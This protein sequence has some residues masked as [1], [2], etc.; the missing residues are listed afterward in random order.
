MTSSSNV[1]LDQSLPRTLDA[2]V[3]QFSQ[4][5]WHGAQLEA[6][7]FE[8]AEA[9]RAAEETLAAAGV[10][11][12][13]RSAYKPL[14]HFFL[15]EVDLGQIAS[16]QVCYPVHSAATAQ[17]FW[18][19]AYPLAALLPAGVL[20]GVAGGEALVYQVTLRLKDGST[21]QHQV[22]APNQLQ[23]DPLGH[24]LL[25]PTGWLRAV[26][27]AGATVAALDQACR[28]EVEQL[29]AQ[30]LSTVQQ[31]P[32]PQTEPYFER[33]DIRLDLPGYE[34]AVPGMPGA[35]ETIST[36][37]AL[38]EDLYFSLLEI[39]QHH[40]GRPTGDRR[41]QPGQIVPDVRFGAPRVCITLNSFNTAAQDACAP[42]DT[43]DGVALDALGAAPPPA[44][45][46]HE[47]AQLGGQTF[48][49]STRQGR[50]VV[51]LYRTGSQA[52]VLISGGQHANE[53]SG[54][55]GTLRAAQVLRQQPDAHFALI[56]LENPDGYAM[57]REL[58]AQH[59]EHMHHAARY[60]ALGDD[61]E[62]RETAPLF[63]R[64]AREH[65]LTLSGAQLHL[66]L[67]GYPAHEWT[68]PLSGYIPRGFDL[69]TI[70]KGFFLILRYHT[71]WQAQA[72]ALLEQVCAALREVPGLIDFNAQQMALYAEHAGPMPFPVLDGTAYT[73]SEVNRP[74]APVTLITEFPD[75][76]V[77]GDAFRFAHSVQMATVLAA[78][79]AWQNIAPPLVNPS[80]Q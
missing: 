59:G 2:W 71:G 47:M 24:E 48:N 32:W 39:F 26:P 31:H 61:I 78:T 36:L 54:I 33:L 49:A 34:C 13:L 55:V 46:Q 11:A 14:L 80:K 56:A 23:R 52:P 25:S 45:I 5:A 70:P 68:R 77:Y 7:L 28:T 69:W 73:I 38:H 19:E 18:L 8:G 22:F 37:E 15:E 50:S 29:F 10:K 57:H 21:Q 41:L 20:Q 63:E 27:A 75:E 67:H 35:P 1:L 79:K 6:W 76:T 51:G 74:G 53:T 40:S 72:Q 62:Y 58:C 16:A 30:V 12:R 9:R 4:P 43:T 44:R 3:A 65:A 60:S 64:E 66:N 17:R 42:V